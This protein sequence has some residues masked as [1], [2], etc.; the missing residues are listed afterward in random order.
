[1]KNYVEEYWKGIESGE[2]ITSNR[3][4]QQYKKIIDDIYKD[5]GKYTLDLERGT[6]PIEF[7]EKFCK[8]SKGKWFGQSVILQLFQKAKIQAV[9]GVIDR[10]TN[11][12]KCKEVF[13]LIG[14]K[15][16]KS[17][18][19]SATAL[20]MMMGDGEGGSDVYSV[21]TKKDQAKIVFNESVNMIKQSPEL[22]P[23]VKKKRDGLYF[24]KAF[25]KF[26]PLSSDS[27]TLDGLNCHYVVIDELHAVKNRDLYDVLKQSTP[28]RDQPILDM[29][30]TAGF[31]RECIYDSI[32]E[33]ACDVLDEK[34]EDEHFFAF[35]YEL[36]QKSEWMNP[37]CWVK[38]NPALGTIKSL[39]DLKNNVQR[40]KNDP[41]FLP[42][43]LTKDFNVKDTVAG[44]WLTFEQIENK[45]TF[46]M[47]DIKG[48]Y[49][50]GGVDLSSTSDL[51]CA[52]I[53]VE[54]PD[55]K[56]YVLQKYFI[57]SE[58]LEKRVNEDKIPYD[59]WAKK[60]FIT[61]TEGNKVDYSDVTKWFLQL[62][63]EYEIHVIWVGYDKWNSQYWVKEMENN[64]FRLESVPYFS[65]SQPMKELAADLTAKRINY[66]NNPVL[67]WCL[68]NTT[69]KID[70]YGNMRPIKGKVQRQRIDGAVSLI[71]AF[72]TFFKYYEDYKALI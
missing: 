33:Y 37:D 35:I 47:E 27:Q 23:F 14:R 70:E 44:M 8:Q 18:E 46:T 71:I 32:Y 57:P 60:G 55:G 28:T 42:T 10:E 48:T 45:E 39:E 50:I 62:Q 72:T 61:L 53:I 25:S 16:G 7:I 58:L 29:I 5:N 31:V 52:T 17:T 64:C 36:D 3:I 22:Y 11:L 67:K 68:T 40:A 43:V 34:V 12:R 19:K 21:A 30:T 63:N 1:M 9:Y 13:T 65:M 2:I 51:T 66:D 38:A 15:N 49:A 54:K 4:K 59:V 6:R 24:D 26:E 20:Y 56:K 69:I 41:S